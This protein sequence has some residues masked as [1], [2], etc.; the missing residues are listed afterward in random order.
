MSSS[1]QAASAR[2]PTGG[3]LVHGPSRP[4]SVSVVGCV[5]VPAR[6]RSRQTR[7][8]GKVTRPGAR[9]RAAGRAQPNHHG[10][11]KVGETRAPRALAFPET[12]T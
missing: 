6:P 7:R 2:P 11:W 10:A 8:L 1:R 5:T 12:A 3:G 9:L 4:R